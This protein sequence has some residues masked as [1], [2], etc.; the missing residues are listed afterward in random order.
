MGASSVLFN[1]MNDNQDKQK[2]Y[3][4]NQNLLCAQRVV[5]QKIFQSPFSEIEDD[6]LFKVV[7]REDQGGQ[8]D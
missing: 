7:K 8:N 5:V 1:N 4:P 6:V 3:K 2:R